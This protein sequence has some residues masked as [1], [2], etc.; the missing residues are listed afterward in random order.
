MGR[1]WSFLSALTIL[2]GAALLPAKAAVTLVQPVELDNKIDDIKDALADVNAD[3]AGLHVRAQ[4]MFD[5][6][7]DTHHLPVTGIGEWQRPEALTAD[8]AEEADVAAALR[9]YKG[10]VTSEPPPPIAKSPD[11]HKRILEDYVA[12]ESLVSQDR[13]KKDENGQLPKNAIAAYVWNVAESAKDGAVDG[14]MLAQ[15]A[16]FK[17]A[18]K[19]GEFILPTLGAHEPRHRVEHLQDAKK[20]SDD[21][22]DEEVE[23]FYD[24]GALMTWMDPSG[25]KFM[26]L[27]TVTV[28]RPDTPKFVVEYV[29]HL[30]K[31]RYAYSQGRPA[32]K[33]LVQELGYED[34]PG[35]FQATQQAVQ[36]PQG[37]AAANPL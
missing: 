13:V 25:E 8:P 33:Q 20:L 23:A 19:L 3:P 30:A 28:E 11:A 4:R 36:A 35:Q 18:R 14:M 1:F 10:L 5:Q 22:Q 17:A 9:K 2:C 21:V 7:Q 15:P 6:A 24:E 34:K 16:L 31:V 27:W 32:I 37:A 12:F 29:K 26:Y